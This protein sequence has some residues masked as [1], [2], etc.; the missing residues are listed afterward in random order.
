MW[1]VLG[2][3]GGRSDLGGLGLQRGRRGRVHEAQRKNQFAPHSSHVCLTTTTC[4]YS[5]FYGTL[6][7]LHTITKAKLVSSC[8]QCEEQIS[9]HRLLILPTLSW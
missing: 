5:L 7:A 3:G 2:R 6:E 8:T 9:A 1:V 4:R